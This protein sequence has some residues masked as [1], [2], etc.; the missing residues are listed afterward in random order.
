MTQIEWDKV[1]EK[2]YET[3]VSHGVLYLIDNVGQYT[4]GVPWNGL[5][6]VT[7][8][9][10]GAESNKQYAD[11]IVYANIK[12]AEEVGGT[13]EA[14]T[15]PDEFGDCD[16]TRE[17]VPGVLIGQQSRRS[18]GFS[19][20]SLVGNDLEGTDFGY[21]IH[22]VYGADANPSEKQYQ[23]VNDSPEPATLS[24]EYTTTPVSV[25][26][27]KPA[28]KLTI[29]STD[30][31]AAKLAELEEILYGTEGSDPRLPLPAEIIEIVTGGA[32]VE[33]TP[34]KPTQVGNVIT[35]PAVTGAIY[36]INGVDVVA[37][38]QDPITDDVLVRVRATAGYK[39]PS[40]GY[41]ADWLFE[42][43]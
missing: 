33:I 7:D 19:W 43:A 37:G 8:S 36:S 34:A 42:H 32:P 12:S 22:L 13:I 24:W 11:N 5:V 9:P 1:G 21:K 35:I 31:T 39:L 23:T 27:F 17:I 2:E 18:F 25:P 16:G 10:S 4:N 29:K 3:G 40:S 28:S 41:D 26:G 20:Q 15:A 6:S 14:F 30:L 38:A